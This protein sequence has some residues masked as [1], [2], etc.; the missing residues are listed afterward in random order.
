MRTR[1]KAGN[2]AAERRLC[3][4][5]L[6]AAIAIACCGLAIRPLQAEAGTAAGTLTVQLTITSSCTIGAAT[7]NFGSDAGT[8]LL[9]TAL[10]ANTTVSVTC[11]NGSPY[12]IGMGQGSYYSSGNRMANGTNYI[13]YALYQNSSLTTPWTTA[14]SSTTCTTTGDCDLGTGNGTAQTYT[15]YGQVPTVAVA[16]A[17]GAD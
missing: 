12:A 2:Q 7:L 13:P 3:L 17:P 11:T 1:F 9:S 6:F 14:A 16:A 15:I 8:S 5:S 4:A 10:T